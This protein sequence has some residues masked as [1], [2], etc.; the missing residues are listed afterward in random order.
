MHRHW[1]GHSRGSAFLRAA[2]IAASAPSGVAVAQERWDTYANPRFGATAE[3]PADL[4]STQEPPPEN[5]DG[6]T[7]HTADGRAELTIYGANNIDSDKPKTYV[8][9]NVSLDG[10]TF[11]K[12]TSKFYAVSGKRGGAI[13]YERCDFPDR[14]VLNCVYIS[15]PAAEKAAWDKIVA[16]ISTSL[17]HSPVSYRP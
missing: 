9:K 4:F 17:R 15:Y 6:Q 5:G 10:V 11:K 1:P 3:Y 13:F 14:D 2:A 8:E 12:S 7:F 16:R